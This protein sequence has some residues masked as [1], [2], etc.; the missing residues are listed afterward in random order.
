MLPLYIV[1][2]ALAVFT[3]VSGWVLESSK[4]NSG[5]LSV[6]NGLLLFLFVVSL[7][8]SVIFAVV[9]MVVRFYKNLM[10][11]RLS[12]AKACSDSSAMRQKC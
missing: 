10:V 8:A 12:C 9:L 4:Q 3:R 2:A 5:L 7:I 6:V 11:V 1:I